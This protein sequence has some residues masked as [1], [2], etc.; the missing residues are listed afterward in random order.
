MKN[1]KDKSVE[2][3]L[4]ERLKMRHGIKRIIFVN[5]KRMVVDIN[6]ML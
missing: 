5:R 6:N 4:L 2:S 1:I 3:F